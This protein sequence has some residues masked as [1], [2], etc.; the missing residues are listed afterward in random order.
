MLLLYCFFKNL[1]MYF[2]SDM[3]KEFGI[4]KMLI[5]LEL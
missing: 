2:L 5:I 3:T 1:F 4:I